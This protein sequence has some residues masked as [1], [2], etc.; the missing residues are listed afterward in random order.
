MN[1]IRLAHQGETDRQKEIWQLCFG[2]SDSY[3]DFF[4]AN[5]Y[6]EDETLLLLQDREIMAMLTM[7]PVTVIAA[8][9][10]SFDSTMLYA[11]ATHPKYQNRGFA[12]QLMNYANQHLG[13]QKKVFSV[14][15]PSGEKL[16]NF[17]RKQG[18]Q[19]GFYIRETLL[20]ETMIESVLTDASCQCT[21][22]D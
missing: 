18:Y 10:Q 6:Q 3:I 17:Y 4:Y 16:F 11:I 5:R 22:S 2:D 21:I 9:G 12:T 19:D 15:V 1:E 7:I 14:L 13:G 20:T 8:D